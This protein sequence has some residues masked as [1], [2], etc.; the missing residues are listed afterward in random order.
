MLYTILYALGGFLITG[1]GVLT[2]LAM[3]FA[4]PGN[5]PKTEAE[6]RTH[7]RVAFLIMA[8]PVWV[9]LFI[10]AYFNNA[11]GLLPGPARFICILLTPAPLAAMALNIWL[12]SRNRN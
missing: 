9:L 6:K 2:C 10:L 7:K 5:S 12:G 8:T 1:L 11:W 3:V 4:T